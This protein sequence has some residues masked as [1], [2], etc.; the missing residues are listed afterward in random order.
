MSKDN[1]S[2]I[3]LLFIVFLVYKIYTDTSQP[4]QVQPQQVQQV[5]PQ[6]VQP[7][8]P[9]Q[10][11]IIYQQAPPAGDS[12]PGQGIIQDLNQETTVI[13]PQPQYIQPTQIPYIQPQQQFDSQQGG[14]VGYTQEFI[15]EC[16][17]KLFNDEEPQSMCFVYWNDQQ[18]IEGDSTFN[19]YRAA[20]LAECNSHS[21]P[22][23]CRTAV[24][25]YLDAVMAAYNR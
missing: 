5:Q 15:N 13:V 20:K 16:N 9:Q 8:Q 11:V 14:G 17:T 24:N 4:Q 7:Q 21:N 18:L 10:P 3:V 23:G 1:I 6:Q 19:Q 22:E 2:L 12:I 25:V